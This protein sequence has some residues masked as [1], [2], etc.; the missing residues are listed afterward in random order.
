MSQRRFPIMVGVRVQR[1]HVGSR[2]RRLARLGATR[3]YETPEQPSWAK[4]DY[5]YRHRYCRAC[6]RHLGWTRIEEATGFC[7][8]CRPA[9]RVRFSFSER[10]RMRESGWEWGET[11]RRHDPQY[12]TDWRRSAELAAEETYAR[13]LWQHYLWSHEPDFGMRQRFLMKHFTLRKPSYDERIPIWLYTWAE[14]EYRRGE[15][16]VNER[17][18]A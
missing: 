1:W 14:A 8:K 12:E 4:E 5:G 17:E 15:T 7:L 3:H 6:G 16:E 10:Q 11:V 9:Q 13:S 2:G 18:D